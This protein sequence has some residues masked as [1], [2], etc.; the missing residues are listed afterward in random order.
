MTRVPFKAWHLA[1]LDPVHIQGRETATLEYGEILEAGGRAYTMLDGG[2]VIACAGILDAGPIGSWLWSYLDQR[3]GRAMLR[4]HR[5]ALEL[6]RSHAGPLR[7]ATAAGFAPGCR[8]LEMLGFTLQG[9][10]DAEFP[11][12]PGAL[13]YLRGA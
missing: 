5:V 3:T 1:A 12:N 4:F 10:L 13:S 9:T 8:W 7:A 11:D 6:I 2:R